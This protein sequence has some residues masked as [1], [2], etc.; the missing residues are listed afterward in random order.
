[1]QCGPEFWV[2]SG[3]AVIRPQWAPACGLLLRHD[4]MGCTRYAGGLHMIL[5]KGL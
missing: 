3:R 4:D 2:I 1:M 5:F